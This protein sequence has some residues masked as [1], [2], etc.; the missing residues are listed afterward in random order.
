MNMENARKKKKSDFIWWIAFI[1]IIT[2]LINKSA[3]VFIE[4]IVLL[5]IW[6]YFAKLSRK[7]ADTND[8]AEEKVVEEHKEYLAEVEE[9]IAVKE[10]ETMSKTDSFYSGI[11]ENPSINDN[12]G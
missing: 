10:K 12:D 2:W 8:V 11:S 3:I 1:I 5:G 6:L 4:V 9:I 7:S